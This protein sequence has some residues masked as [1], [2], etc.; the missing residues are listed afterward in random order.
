MLDFLAILLAVFTVAFALY[1]FRGLYLGYAIYFIKSTPE[2]TNDDE[3]AVREAL[4]LLNESEKS[5]ELCDDGDDSPNSLYNDD[6]LVSTIKR[7]LDNNPRI[8]VEC[9]LNFDNN[10]K[11]KRAFINNPQ[12]R[13]Y[14]RKKDRRRRDVHYK[15]VD[16]IKAHL[17][18]HGPGET[19]RPYKIVDISDAPRFAKGNLAKRTFGTHRPPKEDFELAGVDV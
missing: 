17:S 11:F 1:M 12:V 5:I 4:C 7:K 19:D 6:G 2:T 8:Q 15:I 9:F 3:M 14:Y 16:N 10:T 13:I 18:K